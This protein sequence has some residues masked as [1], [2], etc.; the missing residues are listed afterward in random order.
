M[1]SE[2]PSSCWAERCPMSWSTMTEDR[3]CHDLAGFADLFQGAGV[4]GSAPSDSTPV[5]DLYVLVLRFGCE[6]FKALIGKGR[7]GEGWRTG[8]DTLKMSYAPR[9]LHLLLSVTAGETDPSRLQTRVPWALVLSPP[10]PCVPLGHRVPASLPGV[11]TRP[12]PSLGMC[13]VDTD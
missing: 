2:Q 7:A 13:F 3:A 1:S 8:S 6:T 9:I 4:L 12:L 5:N 10:C 11:S